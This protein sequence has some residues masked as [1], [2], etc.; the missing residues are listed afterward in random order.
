MSLKPSEYTLWEDV[1]VRVDEPKASLGLR[2]GERVLDSLNS[3]EDSKGN[4]GDRGALSV[5]NLRL[6]WVSHANPRRNMS[7]G[8]GALAPGRE[9]LAI[10]AAQS[11]LRGSLQAL[12]VKASFQGTRFDFIFTSL[13]KASPRL[14]SVAQDTY[15]CAGRRAR[16]AALP[17]PR[18]KRAR[19]PLTPHPP[20]HPPSSLGP[21][22]RSAYETSRLYRSVK[23]RGAIVNPEDRSVVLLPR[24]RVFSQTDGVWNL[25]NDAGNLGSA[26]VTSAR[27][28]WRATLTE[29]FNVSIPYVSMTRVGVSQQGKFGLTLVI[30]TAARDGG[31]LFGFRVEPPEKLTQLEK[32]VRALREVAFSAP[33]FGVAVVMEGDAPGGSGGGGG[34]PLAAGGEDVEIVEPQGREGAASD[35]FA[36]Y[37]AEGNKEGDREVVFSGELGLAV[38]APP[39]G[40]SVAQLWATL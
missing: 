20:A 26:T 38:E 27:F 19:A 21:P 8:W 22:P 4:S 16:R 3:V 10:R 5:T 32:E 36:A 14:F 24:E 6:L 35:A 2:R 28:V 30:G 31:C 18:K 7:V 25:A 34:G 17:A 9:G 11:R 12:V 40:L 1:E 13:V 23:L 33:D 37:L 15:R 29:N 39:A